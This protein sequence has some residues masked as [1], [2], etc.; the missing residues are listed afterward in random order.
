[1]RRKTVVIGVSYLCGLFLASFLSPF[2][3]VILLASAS[4]TAPVLCIIKRSASRYIAVSALSFCVGVMLYTSYEVN[5][6]DKLLSLD[7]RELEIVGTVDDYEHLEGDMVKLSLDVTLEGADTTITFTANDTHSLDYGDTVTV[8][9]TVERISDNIYSQTMQYNNSKGIYLTGGFAQITSVIPSGFSVRRAML[10]YRDLLSETIMHNCDSEVAGFLIA[11][12]CGDKTQVT[13][14]MRL[15]LSRTGLLHIFSVSGLHL[16]IVVFMVSRLLG[17]FRVGRRK[18]FL[19]TQLFVTA[20]VLLAGCSVSVMRAALM[21]TLHNM[22]R[23][24]KR[25][26]DPLSSVV[27]ACVVITAFSPC[28]VRNSSLLLSACGAFSMAVL[29][30]KVIASLSPGERFYKT[31]CTFLSLCTLTVVMLPMTLAFFSEVSVIAVA[32]NLTL[33]PLCSAALC[34]VAVIAVTGAVPV[35]AKPLLMCAGVL[36]KAVMNVSKTLSDLGFSSAAIGY[37]PLKLAMWGVIALTAGAFI[38]CRRNTVRQVLVSLSGYI[39]CLVCA[40]VNQTM[41]GSILRIYRLS[42]KDSCMMLVALGRECIMVN[43]SGD[44]EVLPAM[45][46]LMQ[47]KGIRSVSA[48]YDLSDSTTAFTYFCDHLSVYDLEADCDYDGFVSSWLYEGDLLLEYDELDIAISAGEIIYDESYDVVIC[49][50]ILTDNMN[51]RSFAIFA[52]AELITINDENVTVRR[53]PYGF[54]E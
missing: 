14:A 45:G 6:V 2:Y 12:L 39:V 11:M 38:L 36:I 5:T 47:S 50:D 1:M 44:G 52:D 21:I 34:L 28:S 30:P 7:G 51:E 26:Y 4:I 23:I 22:R 24:T 16:V 18:S 9:A 35:I 33:L 49:K 17:I 40:F 32:A 37:R 48:F 3:S 29:A 54:D 27:L 43:I 19:I 8:K 13:D 20:F 15:T 25:R 41:V 46:N 42:D 53:L 31:K 10:T